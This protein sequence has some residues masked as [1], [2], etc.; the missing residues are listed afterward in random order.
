MQ[1]ISG[2]DKLKI[3]INFMKEQNLN[4]THTSYDIIDQNGKI[5][6]NRKARN[7]INIK[8]LLKSCDIGLSTVMINKKIVDDYCNF[9][10][11]K[12]KKTLYFG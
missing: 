11:T 12:P 1:M 8:D 9:G 7:F 10:D 5:I 2:K 6:G 3:Q 4:T